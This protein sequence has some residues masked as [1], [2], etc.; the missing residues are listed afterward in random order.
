MLNLYPLCFCPQGEPGGPPG[1]KGEKVS[2]SRDGPRGHGQLTVEGLCS[3]AVPP[4][5]EARGLAQLGLQRGALPSQSSWRWGL[6]LGKQKPLQVAVCCCA[7]SEAPQVTSVSVVK[8]ER[9]TE[10][11]FSLGSDTEK[12][13]QQEGRVYQASGHRRAGRDRPAIQKGAE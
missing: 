5:E 2:K 6:G 7:S 13:R 4:R 1:P 12:D 3:K 8:V 11:S 9:D 10:F